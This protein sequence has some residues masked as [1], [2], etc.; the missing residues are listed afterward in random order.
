MNFPEAIA[1]AADRIATEIGAPRKRIAI[2]FQ[3]DPMCEGD[4]T[5]HDWTVAIYANPRRKNAD[6]FRVYGYGEDL[7]EAGVEAVK[8][9]YRGLEHDKPFYKP[10]PGDKGRS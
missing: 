1:A 2:T 4:E 6:L 10:F 8:A 7:S 9:Y 3:P 5:P